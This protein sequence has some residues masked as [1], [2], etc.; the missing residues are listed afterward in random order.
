MFSIINTFFVVNQ[1]VQPTTFVDQYYKSEA[2]SYGTL[3]RVYLQGT[4]M[5]QR[6]LK[7]N[8]HFEKKKFKVGYM[9]GYKYKYVYANWNDAA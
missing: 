8:T 9:E 7:K 6:T 4:C 1:I 2:N 3:R 5:W